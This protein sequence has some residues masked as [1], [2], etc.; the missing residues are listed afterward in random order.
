MNWATLALLSAVTISV[1]IILDKRLVS[2]NIRRSQAYYIWLVTAL[3]TLSTIIYLTVGIQDDL[4]ASKVL[5]AYGAGLGWGMGLALFFIGV[6][7]EE[8]SRAA[9]IFQTFPIFV[10]IFAVIFLGESVGVGQGIAIL[11]IVAGAYMISLRKLSFSAALRPSKALPLLLLASFSVGM[12]FFG[13]KVALESLSIS[14]VYVFRSMGMVTILMLFFRPWMLPEMVSNFKHPATRYLIFLNL[15]V[16]API[17]TILS[18]IATDLG[19]V[20]LVSSIVATSP[21]FVFVFTALLTKTRLRSL[22]EPVHRETLAIKGTSVCL[23]VGG[24][25]A[26][27]IL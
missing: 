12:G 1:V 25:I 16:L 23:V 5:I 18:L 3:I 19:P 11:N 22:G 13:N 7:L 4:P 17:V 21:M 26:L 8:A 2:V 14:T 24:L 27:Q 10:A 9:A 15:F 20:S 6:K